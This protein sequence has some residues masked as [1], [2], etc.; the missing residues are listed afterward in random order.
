M[1][2]REEKTHEPDIWS[3][4]NSEGKANKMKYLLAMAGNIIDLH[5]LFIKFPQLLQQEQQD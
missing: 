1:E 5:E 2:P 3:W 4:T